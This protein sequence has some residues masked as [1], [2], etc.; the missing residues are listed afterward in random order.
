QQTTEHARREDNTN[1]VAIE[2]GLAGM[3]VNYAKCC[4]PLPGEDIVGIIATGKGVSVHMRTCRNLEQ[5]ADQP[6]RWLP[7]SWSKAAENGDLRHFVCRLRFHV[8]NDTGALASITN[9]IA[10]SNAQIIEIA[11]ENRNAD[12]M[13]IRCEMEITNKNHLNRLIQQLSGLKVMLS[14]EKIYGWN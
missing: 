8:R 5:F 7:V 13:T 3:V 4:S 10:N 1:K 14:V 11:T 9:V 12:S 6:D 2:G